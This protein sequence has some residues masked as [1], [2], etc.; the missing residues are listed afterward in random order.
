MLIPSLLSQ[1]ANTN[2]VYTR[3]RDLRSLPLACIEA[4]TLINQRSGP[5]QLPQPIRHRLNIL[6]AVSLHVGLDARVQ[7]T[8]VDRVLPI[9]S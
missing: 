9:D 7:L 4:A 2:L 1:A 3:R 6:V 8:L 5:A